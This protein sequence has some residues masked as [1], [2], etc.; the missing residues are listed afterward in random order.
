MDTVLIEKSVHPNVVFIVLNW[1]GWQD[2]LECLKSIDKVNY[3]N[4]FF[5]LADNDSED[6]SLDRIRSYC[7]TKPD[8]KIN[9][10]SE[11]SDK[12]KN[13]V[14]IDFENLNDI[15]INLNNSLNSNKLKNI[16]LIKNDENYG[17][18]GGNN[19]A[20]NFAKQNLKPDYYLLL[21]NDTVVEPDF[22]KNMMHSV[23]KHDNVGFA[24][25]KI[26][27]YKPAEVSNLLSFTGG[28]INLNTSEPSPVGK[29]QIDIGQH[30]YDRV[31]DYVEGSCMLV[32]S[33]LAES[34]GF[35]NQDY[36]TYWEEI[37]WC[38]RGKTAGFNTIYTHKAKIW[39]KCYGSDI[40]AM[41]IYYMIRNRFLFMKMNETMLQ[42]FTS[43][44]YY[45]CYY[46]WKI[47]FS[48][49][50]IRRDKIKLRSFLDGTLDGIKN[51]KGKK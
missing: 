30:E 10:K 42:Q 1:N 51:I 6:D 13:L 15:K 48:L 35:F 7:N 8:H 23:Q 49:V 50:F 36:F 22:L 47:L 18:T 4:Y 41:S 34:V 26:Y 14:E 25:P 5:I 11:I 33:E 28:T 32:S 43:I 21:N 46:F 40:G 12:I 27:Y 44:I 16:I 20:L 9:K 3:P 39:H 29:D 37:D 17:F 24:G 19:I 31:V 38:I 45:F 2:T